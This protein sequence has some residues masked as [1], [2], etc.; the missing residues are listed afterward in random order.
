LEQ[1]EK[2]VLMNVVVT[3]GS[4][5]LGTPIIT[6]LLSDG[7]QVLSLS[8]QPQ[9][10]DW[11]QHANLTHH[12]V[13]ISNTSRL[14][15]YFRPFVDKHGPINGLV[16]LT[17]RS[18]RGLNTKT[19]E[20]NFSRNILMAVE[21]TL[22]TLLEVRPFLDST[23]SV[24]VISS[25]WAKRV[26]E[27]AMYLDLQ[28]EPDLSVPAGKAAQRQVVQ[29]LA[30]EWARDGIRV[31]LVTPGWFPRP[32]PIERKD[33]IDEI[34]KRTPMRRIGRPIDLV[35]PIIFLLSS[36]SSF[37]TGQDLIVDGGFSLW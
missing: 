11:G 25:L 33:Y 19:S 13:E 31:N 20:K 2:T 21:P 27:S 9:K 26:P 22:R 36:G 23:A 24:I 30:V 18:P 15:D 14:Q 7:C 35:E 6:R 16:T 29:Y 4:G 8:S 32:G 3:G 5:H 1:S 34:I 37:I 10:A 17:S 28:N 12:V